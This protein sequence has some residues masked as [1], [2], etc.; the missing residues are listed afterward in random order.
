[1][2]SKGLVPICA[3]TVQRNTEGG[4]LTSFQS[5]EPCGCSYESKV[6]TAPASCVACTAATPCPSDQ[7]CSH[8]FCEAA[9]GRS[10]I[11]DCTAP[12]TDADIPNTPCSGRSVAAMRPQPQKEID[13]GGT[14]PPLP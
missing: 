2:A 4:P 14:L 7:R 8:G 9:N 11:S 5:D 12:A 1:M 3:M 13:N 6:G 10:S